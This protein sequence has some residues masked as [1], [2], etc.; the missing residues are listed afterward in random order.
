MERRIKVTIISGMVSFPQTVSTQTEDEHHAHHHCSSNLPT[1]SLQSR[2]TRC[3]SDGHR[4]GRLC[5]LLSARLFSKGPSSLEP[6]LSPRFA[7]QPSAQIDR[8]DGP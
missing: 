6:S 1:P 2:A 4:L 7:Q 5:R 8:T 3:R